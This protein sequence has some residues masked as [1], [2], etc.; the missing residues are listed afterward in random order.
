MLLRGEYTST[1]RNVQVADMFKEAGVIERY[2]SGIGRIVDDFKAYGLAAPE[3]KEVGES[4]IVT[5]SKTRRPGFHP[6]TIQKGLAERLVERLAESQKKIL[7]LMQANPNI[8]KKDLAAAVGISTTAIDKNISALKAKGLLIRI[9][10]DKGGHWSLL[11]AGRGK[12]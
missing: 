12:R 1:P 2:G 4:F 8:S 5:V 10:P 9:G 6:N 11:E 7:T 3:F